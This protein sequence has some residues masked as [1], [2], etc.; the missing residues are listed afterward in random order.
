[1]IRLGL[2]G[3]GEHS[4]S[5]HAIPLARYKSR[6]P[7][8]IELVAACDVRL[9]RAQQFCAKYG[10]LSAFRD[11]D[12][13]LQ[14]EKLDGIIAVVPPE[15][16]SALAIELLRLGIPCVVEKP[17]GA[18][19]AE[20]VALRDAAAATST[21][22]MVSVNRRFMP[23]LTRAIA[24]TRA[25]GSLR[26]VR[27]TLAREARREAEFL[28]ATAV[29]AMD[30]VRFIAGEVAGFEIHTLTTPRGAT[31]WHA[32]DL[33]FENGILGRIDVL[34]T[35]GMLEE[36]YDLFGEGFRASVTCPF[37]TERGWRCF[38]N[39][40]LISDEVAPSEAPEDTVNGCYDEA[41]EFIR[42]L[43]S[44]DRPQPSIEEVFP[45]VELCWTMGRSVGAQPE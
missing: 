34:P 22:N 26:Y 2:I 18:S 32:V 7:G 23:F 20:A 11:M 33:R 36:T 37:G 40:H 4:E 9:E 16:I 42:A 17:L 31:S 24:W 8:H 13:M 41:S 3:C 5:G 19:L 38:R 28:W 21:P 1:M 43:G 30:T 39:G 12:E 15:R 35:T 25:S 44:K 27:C 6:N 29:H 45:S 10:F 14:G